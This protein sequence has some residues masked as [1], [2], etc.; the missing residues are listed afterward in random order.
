MRP[1]PPPS[2]RAWLFGLAKPP[3][4]ETAFSARR[5]G[6]IVRPRAAWIQRIWDP[7][8]CFS[9]KQWGAPTACSQQCPEENDGVDARSSFGGPVH[10]FQIQP[11]SKFVKRQGGAHAV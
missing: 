7:L 4:A 2:W 11:E 1:S 6:P 5:G 9:V 10:V 3:S 8:L